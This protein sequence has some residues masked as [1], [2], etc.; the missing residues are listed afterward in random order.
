M[1]TEH[2]PDRTHQPDDPVCLQ[3][4]QQPSAL[5][6]WMLNPP[7]ARRTF[8]VRIGERVTTLPGAGVIRRRWWAWQRRQ[9]L[10]ERY[11]NTV[12]VIALFACFVVSL[13]L[14]LAIYS[15]YGRA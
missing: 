6:D 15:L 8:G 1:T 5:P 2:G 11:P 7:P 13:A 14:M 9:P 10:R 12:K 3:T 4:S